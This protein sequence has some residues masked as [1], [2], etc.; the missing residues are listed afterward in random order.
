MEENQLKLLEEIQSL[1]YNIVRCGDCGDVFIHSDK[2]E[3][4]VCPYCKNE[5]EHSDCSDLFYPSWDYDLNHKN[6]ELD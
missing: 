4:L 1:G 5:H 3:Y 6:T 2:V